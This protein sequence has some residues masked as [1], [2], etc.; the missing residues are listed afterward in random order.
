[1]PALLTLLSLFL[2]AGLI[3]MALLKSLGSLPVIAAAGLAALFFAATIARSRGKWIEAKLLRSWGGWTTTT[4]LRHVDVRIDP[5][6]KDRYHRAIERLCPGLTLPS[7]AAETAN[8]TGADDFYRSATKLLIE[9]RRGPEWNLLLQEN[10]SYGFRRNMLGLKPIAVALAILLAVVTLLYWWLE[11]GTPPNFAATFAVVQVWPGPLLLA[12]LNVV[13]I[14]AWVG[15][16]T[17]TWV[18]QASEDYSLA[19]FRT[20]DA[21]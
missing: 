2:V 14:A 20:L 4:M 5:V 3:G 10:I 6:T 16:V 1:M 17:P 18:R 7:P 9:K 11:G 19:L 21:P 12:L 15:F 8:P 13:V